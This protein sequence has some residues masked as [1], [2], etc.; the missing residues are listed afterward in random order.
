MSPRVDPARIDDYGDYLF[1]I[2]QAVTAYRLDEEMEPVEVDFYLGQNYVVSC[3]RESVPAIEQFRE[4]CGRDERPLRRT[5]DWVLHGIVDAI[6]DE[7]LPI[8]DD[9]DDDDR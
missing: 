2:V 6:V 4:R 1:I 8:V 5:P 7:Y 9:V 3:H